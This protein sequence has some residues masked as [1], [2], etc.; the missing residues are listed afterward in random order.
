MPAS[1]TKQQNLSNGPVTLKGE[2][3]RRIPEGAH[4]G[5]LSFSGLRETQVPDGKGGVKDATY[6]HVSIVDDASG[7]A[8]DR[9]FPARVTP[10]TEL[11]KLISVMTGRPVVKGADYDLTAILQGRVRF[12]TQDEQAKD[13]SGR[14]FARVVAGTITPLNA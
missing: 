10:D 2:E 13:G 7:I 12:M 11:G 5:S 4:T 9:G 14:V 3:S 8:L 1:N 6:A